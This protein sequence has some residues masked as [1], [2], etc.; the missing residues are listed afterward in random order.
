M[1]KPLPLF[2]NTKRDD[3]FSKAAILL[4]DKAKGDTLGTRK[5][6][7]L[8]TLTLGKNLNNHQFRIMKRT[9]HLL[10]LLLLLT[11][12]LLN[13]AFG[14]NYRP[15]SNGNIYRFDS[16]SGFYSIKVDS[17]TAV[18][19]DSAF[20][21]NKIVVAVPDTFPGNNCGYPSWQG[22]AYSYGNENVLGTK[23]LEKA[24]GEFQFIAETG[25]T[26]F[27]QTQVPLLSSWTF[28]SDSSLTA[29]ISSRTLETFHGQ[30]DSVLTIS[31]SNGEE[32]RISKNY[33]LLTVH[34]FNAYWSSAPVTVYQQRSLPA[35]PNYLDF[36][37]FEIGDQFR[38]FESSA[39][40][41]SPGWTHYHDGFEVLSRQDYPNGD[42]IGYSVARSLRRRG[43]LPNSIPF[44]S[45]MPTDTITWM[46]H[47][48]TRQFLELGTLD[49]FEGRLLRQ[50]YP[51]IPFNGRETFSFTRYVLDTCNQTLN[52]YVDG[53]NGQ[54]YTIGLGQTLE[55]TYANV[56]RERELTC[57][58]KQTDSVAPCAI[59][60]VN[61]PEPQA[62]EMALNISPNP[63]TES[64]TLQF[65]NPRGLRHNLTVTNMTGQVV[66]KVTE[67]VG[68]HILLERGEL[69]PGLYFYVLK[70]ADG[71]AGT[72]K[73]LV[74]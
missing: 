26:I 18:A 4:K 5:K 15:F 66:R 20:W 21:F 7:Y 65:A 24:N 42:S 29:M 22:P 3:T 47:R 53:G 72:G 63:F 32:L 49:Q 40:L 69:P 74:K 23:M 34:N 44:D 64:T 73:L 60:L 1:E 50:E 11:V 67:I 31:I 17:A 54:H 45:V 46:F 12:G 68:D 33:G 9:S 61:I 8:T 43:E 70:S 71:H 19:A 51:S 56:D 59:P 39:I 30:V 2:P 16:P 58:V 13:A 35:K 38:F 52:W 36:Y 27:I 28:L 37:D 48:D 57:Y 55:G 62:N 10:L 6:K 25:D 14:Q 41:G